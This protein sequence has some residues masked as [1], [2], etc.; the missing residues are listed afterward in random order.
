VPGPR[1]TPDYH[2]QAKLCSDNG[3]IA[4]WLVKLTHNKRNWGFGL[5]H[6]Y[7]RNVKGLKWSTQEKF[8]VVVETA[9]LN[10]PVLSQYCHNRK[11]RLFSGITR[12]ANTSASCC[13]LIET[14]KAN[15]LDPYAYILHILNHISTADTLEKIE[16]L[17]I[18]ICQR[19]LRRSRC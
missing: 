13:S 7:L 18:G 5:C 12:G 11:T 19:I 10:E 4:D 9:S 15:N 3:H 14:A 1:K 2:Y 6:L 17:C 16:A 8:S